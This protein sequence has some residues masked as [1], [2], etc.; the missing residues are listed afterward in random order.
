[1]YVC[2]KL[3]LSLHNFPPEEEMEGHIVR[4]VELKNAYKIL[5]QKLERKRPLGRLRCRWN[6]STKIRLEWDTEVHE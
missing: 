5:V 4:I 6:T 3:I 1:M 2:V